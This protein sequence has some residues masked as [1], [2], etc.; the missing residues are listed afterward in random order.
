MPQS[1]ANVLIHVIFSTKNRYPFI[2]PGIENELYPYLAT[3][4]RTC[5]CPAIKIGGTADHVHI[6]VL[7]R[8]R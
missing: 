2:D 6:A 8:E 7:W 4:C 1:L 5:H 3:A